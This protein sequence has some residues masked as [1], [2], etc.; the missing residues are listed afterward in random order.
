MK[1]NKELNEYS[2]IIDV[3]QDFVNKMVAT[4]FKAEDA[5]SVPVFIVSLYAIDT[6]DQ[7]IMLTIVHNNSRF[8]EQLFPRPDG[9]CYSWE[10]KEL[11]QILYNRTQ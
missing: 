7:R 4:E 1:K 5:E 9:Y 10:I 3:L 6:G 2:T 11:M 8:S